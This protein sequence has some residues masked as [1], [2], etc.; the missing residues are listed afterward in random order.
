MTR[1]GKIMLWG[2][3]VT[4][5]IA[6]G[7]LWALGHVGPDPTAIKAELEMRIEELNRIPPEEAIRRDTLAHEL[8][9]TQDYKDHAKALWLKVERLHRSIHDAAELERAATK[10]VPAFLA[11]SK[12]LSKVTRADLELLIGEARTLV[13]NYGATRFGDP[14]R[15]R[16]GELAAKLESMPK[17]VRAPEV[18]ELNRKVKDA[19][20]AGRFSDA[21]ELVED[22]LKRPGALEYIT[23]IDSSADAIR[24]KAAAVAPGIK[25]SIR[26]SLDRKDG[27]AARQLLDRAE[28]DYR[29]FPKDTE[30]FA[31]LRR[32]LTPR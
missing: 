13:N 23:Q 3:A 25:Q 6:I 26:D 12:D 1:Q 28:L 17:P 29:R 15:K 2:V 10:E 19:L 18:P 27:D 21:L 30:D 16:Q 5:V 4:L 20:R 24:A 14:L 7:A 11:R 32:K 8:R 31:A 22:F 9:D